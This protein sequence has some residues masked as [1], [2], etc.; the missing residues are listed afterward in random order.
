MDRTIIKGL[1]KV[2]LLEAV[3]TGASSLS[4]VLGETEDELEDM[5]KYMDNNIQL[6][7]LRDSKL[8]KGGK[9]K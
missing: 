4:K 3:F 7:K 5:I 8:F 9:Q 1:K 6:Q 2:L